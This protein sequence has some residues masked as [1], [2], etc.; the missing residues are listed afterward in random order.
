MSQLSDRNSQVECLSLWTASYPLERAYCE[1]TSDCNSQ[2]KFVDKFLIL[3][4]ILIKY[5]IKHFIPLHYHKNLRVVYKTILLWYLNFNTFLILSN[6]SPNPH[7]MF[8][9]SIFSALFEIIQHIR[10][11]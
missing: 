3:T 10:L 5:L 8:S 1:P 11:G 4:S 7:L 9:F 6:P 2:V